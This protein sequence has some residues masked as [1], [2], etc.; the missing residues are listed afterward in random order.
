MKIVS[1]VEMQ[2]A[3]PFTDQVASHLLLS[4]WCRESTQGEVARRLGVSRVSVNVWLHHGYGPRVA[5]RII[6]ADGGLINE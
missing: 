2:V 5:R 4:R 1:R 6:A 3:A